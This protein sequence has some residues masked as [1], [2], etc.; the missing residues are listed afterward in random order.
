MM[1]TDNEWFPHLPLFKGMPNKT[2]IGFFVKNDNRFVDYVSTQLHTA[3]CLN[4]RKV[5]IPVSRVK[6]IK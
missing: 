4:A 1:K 5:H 6:G 3:V 2:M